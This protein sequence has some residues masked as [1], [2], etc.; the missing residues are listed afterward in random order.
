MTVRVIFFLFLLLAFIKEGSPSFIEGDILLST[1][2]QGAG[3]DVSGGVRLAD[4]SRLWPG[5]KVYYRFDET[6]KNLAGS[7]KKVRDMMDYVE[8]K[9]DRCIQ[10]V[11][12][13]GSSTSYVLVS[14]EGCG[15]VGLPG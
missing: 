6:F 15:E 7:E 14:D 4:P 11:E 1:P 3:Q 12:A 9:L 10:F 5:G 8:K 2:A 13:K